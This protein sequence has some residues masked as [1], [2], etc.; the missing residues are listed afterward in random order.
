[1]RVGAC[2]CMC[3]GVGGGTWVR[4]GSKRG[5]GARARGPTLGERGLPSWPPRFQRPC[6]ERGGRCWCRTPCAL[7]RFIR[8]PA[9]PPLP[10]IC[11]LAL[12]M[13]LHPMAGHFIAEHYTFVKN[14]VSLG[15]EPVDALVHPD[16]GLSSILT[17]F[18]LLRLCGRWH[19]RVASSPLTP[20]PPGNVLLLRS[21]ELSVL[22]RRLPQRAPRFPEHPRLPSPPPEKPRTRVL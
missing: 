17:M 21:T 12:G 3:E 16:W 7:R 4:V 9:F 2:V 18:W 22:Q 14:Q 10:H 13:G 20:P 1:M 19:A 6:Y 8:V 15:W 11:F 5:G